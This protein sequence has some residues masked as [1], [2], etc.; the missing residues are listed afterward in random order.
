M[1]TI[2]DKILAQRLGKARMDYHHNKE[3][4][5]L[6]IKETISNSSLYNK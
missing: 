1:Q 4:A 2:K 3:K 5:V 6:V